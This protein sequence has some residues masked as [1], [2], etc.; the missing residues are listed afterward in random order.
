MKRDT[1]KINF[2]RAK[3]SKE[4]E[5]FDIEIEGSG[6]F[7]ETKK[8]SVSITAAGV[9]RNRSLAPYVALD[10]LRSITLPE[11]IIIALAQRVGIDVSGK[12]PSEPLSEGITMIYTFSN[13]KRT[14]G[15]FS[16]GK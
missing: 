2:T 15:D 11:N 16:F 5:I 13:K 12:Q 6:P 7:I 14:I 4:N 9:E 3:I 10:N 1:I 8:G